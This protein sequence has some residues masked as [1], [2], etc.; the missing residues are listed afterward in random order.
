MPIS[1]GIDPNEGVANSEANRRSRLAGIGQELANDQTARTMEG[2]QELNVAT[3]DAYNNS[4]DPTG[5]QN[6]TTGQTEVKAV[7]ISP[8]PVPPPGPLASMQVPPMAPG[9]SQA[10]AMAP[11]PAGPASAPMAAPAAAMAAQQP[12]QQ[13]PP[14][15]VKAS[16]FDSPEYQRQINNHLATMP[17]GGLA[18]QQI[19]KERDAKIGQVMEQIA[20][21]HI[22]EAKFVAQQNGLNIPDSVYGSADVARG[23][24]L[25]QKAYPDEPDKGQAFYQAFTAAQGDLGARVQAGMAAGGTPTPAGQRELRNA[26]ALAGFNFG[27]SMKMETYKASIPE[28]YATTSGLVAVNPVTRTATPIND[29]GTG[30]QVTGVIGGKGIGAD[31]AAMSMFGNNTPGGTPGQPEIH[32]DELLKGLNPAIGAQ[33]KALAEGRQQFPSGA[34]L[35]APYWQQMISLVSKYDPQFDAVNYNSR[36]KT[37]ADFT[38]GKTADNITALNTAIH[39]L[40]SLSDAYKD[41]GNSSMPMLNATVN[42]V[43]NQLGF[44]NI[45]KNVARVGSDAAAVSHELAKVFRNTGMSEGEIRDWQSRINTDVSPATSQSVIDSALDLMD[46]RL[47]E[48]GQRYNQGMGTTKDPFE[49]LTPTAQK[50]YQ[51]LK[52]LQT[53]APQTTPDTPPS[54]DGWTVER[55]PDGNP[56]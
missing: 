48:L 11:A 14:T 54:N 2:Q 12:A 42:T 37:R 56:Q 35:R 38:S 6:I 17:N 10:A 28:V 44:P 46:G 51:K 55:L 15:A 26:I 4:Q 13:Q 45:Q 36:A 22:D 19:K 18:L 32:G 49:L 16:P 21:G 24:S 5:A 40:G 1:Y 47:Q 23:L 9:A 43:G 39:H 50:V 8:N 20:N 34:A 52:G 31:A 29:S 25:A 3:K 41:L 33:V 27:N 30:K 7:P 53:P